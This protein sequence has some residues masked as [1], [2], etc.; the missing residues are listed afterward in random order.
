MEECEIMRTFIWQCGKYVPNVKSDNAVQ[1][2]PRFEFF[3]R[4]L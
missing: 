1:D 2:Y 4:R 3:F